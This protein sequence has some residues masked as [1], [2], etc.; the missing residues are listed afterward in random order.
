MPCNG[1]SCS[2]LDS[3]SRTEIPPTTTTH[4]WTFSD[5]AISIDTIL[6]QYWPKT[7]HHM[8][9]LNNITN[10]DPYWHK[11]IFEKILTQKL[12]IWKILTQICVHTDPKDVTSFYGFTFPVDY[13]HFYKQVLTSFLHFYLH[14]C[15][16]IFVS[17]LRI[18]LLHT[19]VSFF[20]IC[21]RV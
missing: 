6:C 7:C 17:I 1:F 3:Y 13:L 2:K 4:S 5:I 12:P 15:I 9:F 18:L 14:F 20:F 10:L 16:S 21:A 8:E 19:D 11:N